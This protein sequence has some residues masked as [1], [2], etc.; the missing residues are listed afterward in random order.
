[1]YSLDFDYAEQ[2]FHDLTVQSPENPTYWNLLASSLWLKIVY[3]QEKLNLES[4]AGPRLGTNDSND[5][6]SEEEETRLREVINTAIST[7]EAILIEEP[8]NL[9][10][11][12]ALGVSYGTLATFEATVKR[13]YLSAYRNAKKAREYHMQVL[14][15]DRNFND[16]RLTIGAYDYTLGVIPALLRY[17]FGVVLGM[18]GDKEEGIRQLEFAARLGSRASTNAKMILIVVY[19]REKQYERSLELIEDLH[20]RYPR[21][22]LLEVTQAAVYQ[23]MENWDRAIEV[24]ETILGKIATGTDGYDRQD[25]TPIRFR[26]GEANIHGLDPDDPAGNARRLDRAV[27]T[28]GRIIENDEATDGIREYLQLM[29]NDDRFLSSL[30]PVRD[31]VGVSLRVK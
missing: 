10:A 25:S 14:N 1:M 31:G 16:A 13:A 23:R 28:F 19:N 17:T 6:V 12:Y 24:Y 9:E 5:L 22:Y 29:W 7:A 30:M 27:E 2:T 3:E 26:L 18:G 15:L 21:N 11:L 4:F 8:E 20:S